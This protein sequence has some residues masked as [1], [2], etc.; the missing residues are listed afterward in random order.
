MLSLLSDLIDKVISV[1]GALG[2]NQIN[3][4]CQKNEKLKVKG[5][6]KMLKDQDFIIFHREN[7]LPWSK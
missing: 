5:E 6:L 3:C 1:N 7:Q 4:I 2:E